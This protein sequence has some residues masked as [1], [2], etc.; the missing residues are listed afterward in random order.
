MSETK[1]SKAIQDALNLIPRCY[2]SRVQ[3]GR[4]RVKGGGW[5]HFAETGTTDRIGH[6]AGLII[7][8]EIKDPDG[9]TS[10]QRAAAQ[11]AFREARIA[12]GA[13]GC[14]VSSVPEAVEFVLGVLRE[15][16]ARIAERATP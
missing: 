12:E 15:V 7:Y 3:A 5:M 16:D 6:A 13:I 4:L 9:T 8:M 10:R 14:E 1:I 11:A 2:F